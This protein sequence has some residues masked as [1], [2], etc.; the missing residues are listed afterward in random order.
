MDWKMNLALIA[1]I[2]S[3]SAAVLAAPAHK[4]D[5]RKEWCTRNNGVTNVHLT[6]I[7]TA[8]CITP[9]YAVKIENAERWQSGINDANAY[10]KVAGKRGLL[11]LVLNKW[12][13]NGEFNKAK[14]EIRKRG[15]N[16]KIEKLATYEPTVGRQE[17]RSAALD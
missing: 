12:Q 4:G 2:L 17:S 3:F 14:A 7:H 6:S 9:N 5:P 11:V 13:E 10:G 16:I 1:A 15:L 8:D